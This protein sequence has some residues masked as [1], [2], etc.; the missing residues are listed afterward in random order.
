MQYPTHPSNINALGLMMSH[1]P[2]SSP[3]LFERPSKFDFSGKKVGRLHIKGVHS[4]QATQSIW[5]SYC[6]CGNVVFPSSSNLLGGRTFSC[7]CQKSENTIKH[8][9]K[10]NLVNHPLYIIWCHIKARCYNP[11]D[12]G[13]KNYGGRG[14]G[15]SKEWFSSFQCFFDDMID[16]WRKGLS[17]D[18]IDVNGNYESSNCRWATSIEQGCNK[19]NN[20]KLSLDGETK[21][22][23]QWSRA[24]GLKTSTICDRLA[25]G[26]TIKEA[27]TIPRNTKR[28]DYSWQ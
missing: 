28:K 5:L 3:R 9:T 15:M 24:T 17:I 6:D 4:M 10:H 1:M 13:Y 16:G 27:L 23:S 20:R 25:T 11:K 19:R 12:K 18:R 14:I 8:N 21:T 26:W 2:L 7:G 22:M